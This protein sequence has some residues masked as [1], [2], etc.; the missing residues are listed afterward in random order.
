MNAIYWIRFLTLVL[1][2][3][4]FITYYKIQIYNYFVDDYSIFKN[5][6][7]DY[8]YLNREP[9]QNFIKMNFLINKK[10]S[11]DSFIFGSSRVGKIHPGNIDNGNYYNMTYSEGLPSDHLENIKL[12]LKSK[13]EIKNI[14]IALDNF[15]FLVDPDSHLKQYLRLPHYLT[16]ISEK[17]KLEFYLFYLNMKPNTRTQ[18]QLTDFLISGD[19]RITY[20]YDFFETGMPTLLESETIRIESNIQ[21]H[22]ANKT[23]LN[24]SKNN[25]G[26]KHRIDETINE[27]GAISKLSKIHN[28][29]LIV[30]INPVHMTTYLDANF[31][32]FQ[33]FKNK[34]ST[35][36]N[37]YD[38]SGL[39]YITVNNYFW[40]GTS[41]YRFK[42]G[43]II[44]KIVF[45]YDNNDIPDDI[46]VFVT[47]NNINNHL[48]MLEN[49]IKNKEQIIKAKVLAFEPNI[50]INCIPPNLPLGYASLCGYIP[51]Y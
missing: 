23:F 34:L 45:N 9:N 22:I 51:K 13:V 37:Y 50:H 48:K 2:L 39:N 29:N 24:P 4:G 10:H 11:F 6:E 20:P 8:I 32:D 7:N 27:I 36:T 33:K 28:F 16:D 17:N 40:H 18:A 38:F 42:A 14:I 15:S 35:V 30:I 5:V 46:G 21:N 19:S 41:H 49:Q 47:K 1:V 31:I 3:M 43:D 25:V 12:L 44:K 26:K